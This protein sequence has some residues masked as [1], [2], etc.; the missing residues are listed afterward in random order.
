MDSLSVQAYETS[1]RVAAYD[2]DM[3]LMHPN[4]HKMV[5]AIIAV[6]AATTPAPRLAIDLGTGTGFLLDRLLRRFPDCRAVA[7]D[8]SQQMVAAAKSRLGA[9]AERV[10]FVVGDFRRP[11]ALGHG[12][13]SA[14]AVVSAYALHHLNLQEKARLMG[15]CRTL[16]KENGWLLNAD[17]VVAE[18]EFLEALVQRMRV[19]GIVDRSH[20]QDLRFRDAAQT[21]RFLDELERN[22]CD[23]P[24]R[25]AEDLRVLRESGYRHVA[26]FWKETREVVYGG[27]AGKI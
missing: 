4:R 1:A 17:L 26:V 23:Q 22:E 27:V 16:L 9:L 13:A 20:G 8:G 2:A 3:D 21:R 12:V 24:Q 14:D 7:V 18:D 25:Q 11:E 10:E 5:E 19:S 15:H 6:L